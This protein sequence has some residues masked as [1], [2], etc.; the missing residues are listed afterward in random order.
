MAVLSLLLTL[1]ACPTQLNTTLL[2]DGL[3]IRTP[4]NRRS[5]VRIDPIEALIVAGEWVIPTADA[6][7]GDQT[8]TASK[9]DANGNHSGPATR[10]GYLSFQVDSDKD[11][12]VWLNA[13]GASMVYV[14]KEPRAGDP[15]SFGYLTLPIQLHKGKNDLLFA[16]G[17]GGFRATLEH[18]VEPIVLDFRDATVPDSIEGEAL[19][20]EEIFEGGLTSLPAGIVVRNAT[21]IDLTKAKCSIEIGKGHT[22]SSPLP[23]IPAFSFRKVA[24]FLPR[25]H[26]QT[27][28][29]QLKVNA[30]TK[31]QKELTLRQRNSSESHKRTFISQN[32]GSVQYYGIQPS[33]SNAPGQSLILSLHGAGVEGMGQAEAYGQKDW[34]NLVAATNRRPFG[35]DWEDIGRIDA[36]EV[37]ADAQKRFKPNPKR[38]YLTGHSMGGHGTWQIGAHYPD[39]FAAIGPSAGWISFFTYAGG[40]TYANPTPMESM[41]LR[42]TN[43]SQTLHL[44]SNFF[45]QAVY[46]LHGDADDNVPVAQARQMRTELKD[47]PNLQWHEQGGAGHWWD[48]S[49][50]TGAD[51]VD[52][53]PM[54]DWFRKIQIPQSSNVNHLDFT[55]ISPGISAD[56]HWATI[57]QQERSFEPSRVLLDYN[58][59]A[60]S[61]IGTTSNVRTLRLRRADMPITPT[62]LFIDGNEVE[63][64][65]VRTEVVIQKREKWQQI[66]SVE[67][68]DKNP[69]RSGGFKDVFRNRIVFVYGTGGSPEAKRWSRAK[70]IF[71]AETFYYRGNGS[72][73]VV[74]DSEFDPRKFRDRNVLLYGSSDT[75][76][77]YNKLI[78]NPDV[79]IRQGLFRVGERRM[80]SYDISAAFILPRKDSQIASVGVIGGTG[81]VGMR[82][83]DRMPIFVSGAGF[84]DLIAMRPSMLTNGT[85]GVAAAGYFGNDWKVKSGQIEFQE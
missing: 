57:V 4:A 70:A 77:A 67:L 26:T 9:A 48:V 61:I 32:D 66:P 58:Q 10:G 85:K 34:A 81:E 6:K 44:K 16:V 42:A 54:F 75:N 29:L 82:L 21:S 25:V 80:D 50:E 7:V 30:S 39:K 78:S 13:T 71:D 28:Q 53:K 3:G 1:V 43:A 83:C 79:E 63:I 37:L 76:S 20:L 12:A 56:C 2:T 22:F 74:P 59:S 84:P 18:V 72:V 46:V 49:P 52:W 17:R 47:H 69:S 60:N 62:R 51:C 15:Y 35:F 27:Y 36:L 14:N 65:R 73:D 55:T 19:S 33:T 8:W 5:P 40:V 24:V 45:Q 68:A 41:L 23:R 64:A 31:D 11:K 38:I